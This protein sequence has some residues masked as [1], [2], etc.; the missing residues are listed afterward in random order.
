[1]EPDSS[2]YPILKFLN[3]FAEIHKTRGSLP[4]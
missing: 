1:M 2:A 4:H 3:E